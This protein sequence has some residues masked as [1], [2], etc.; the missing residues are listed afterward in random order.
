MEQVMTT[1]F[2]TG[3]LAAMMRMATPIIFG[4]LGE[5]LCE[6]AGV[7]NLGIEGIMLMGAMT[8]FLTTLTTG[9]LWLGVAAAALVGVL[10][11]LFMA[12]LAV[13]LGLS[14]HVS[15]LGI[16]LFSTGLAMFIYRLAV[17]SPVNPP[18]VRPFTQTAI[19]FLSGI[20][21]LGTALFNQYVLVY[22]ALLLVPLIWFLFYRTSWGLAIRTVGEN[23]FAAD[24]VGI[25][26]NLTRT[27]CLAAGGALMGVGGAF[28]TLAHQNMFLI[29]VVGGRGWIA[30]AMVIFGNWDPAKGMAGAL[31]FGFLDALQL[32]LQGLGFDIPFHLFLIIPYLM[33]VIALV[34]VSR[35]AAAPAG[36]L[37]PYRRE[38]KG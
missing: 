15:G 26:V 24:T 11:S 10:L 38:E 8:G 35:R 17:G 13:Y 7:L 19:P 21:I 29:D 25:N 1:A 3:L 4:T 9:S 33:T 36:L 20:P 34:G 28:L 2:I 12:F 22:I 5:I 18:T 27:L 32:R 14:Q 31:I 16:T 23:P 30:I 6:R 37:K